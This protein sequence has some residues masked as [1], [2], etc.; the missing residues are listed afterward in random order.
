MIANL[1]ES[2]K[3]KLEQMHALWP[4]ETQEFEEAFS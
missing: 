3:I 1:R 2:Q 4:R